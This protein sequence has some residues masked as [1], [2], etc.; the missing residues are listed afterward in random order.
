M[1]KNTS[2]FFIFDLKNVS[3]FAEYITKFI[4]FDKFDR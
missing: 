3:N 4:W 1:N 2:Y